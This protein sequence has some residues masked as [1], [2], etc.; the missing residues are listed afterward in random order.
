MTSVRRAR[1]ACR[2]AFRSNPFF[3]NKTWQGVP[4]DLNQQKQQFSIAYVRAIAA[5]AGYNVYKQE[6]D[7]ESVDLG[8]AATGVNGTTRN[9]RLELQLKCSESVTL[10]DQDFGFWLKLK[11][12]DDLRDGELHVPKLLLVVHV[13]A[14]VDEWIA[15]DE[16]SL[17]MRRCGY[18]HSLAGQPAT[19]NETGCTVRISRARRFDVAALKHVM[20]EIAHKRAL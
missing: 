11:N 20:T 13:P 8:I 2:A 9:P 10:N 19:D 6:V 18:W 3:G 1:L 14:T 16:N 4:V 7:D 15:Q 5:V 17:A 12:Y